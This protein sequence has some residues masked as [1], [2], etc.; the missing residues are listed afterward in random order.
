[1]TDDELKVIEERAKRATWWHESECGVQ[2]VYDGE[3]EHHEEP[4]YVALKGAT[5]G[6]T[7]VTLAHGYD[8]DGDDWN[9]IAHARADV[10]ALLAEVRRLRAALSALRRWIE[11]EQRWHAAED[12]AQ[13]FNG[14]TT[15]E[16]KKMR[17]K[18]KAALNEYESAADALRAAAAALPADE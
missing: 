1:M 15:A 16:A 17:A 11:A 7:F 4:I 5:I 6:D 9:F 13:P 18:A 3:D 12:A 2:I 14:Q 10:P 8:N